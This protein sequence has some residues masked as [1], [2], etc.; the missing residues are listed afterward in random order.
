MRQF[1]NIDFGSGDFRA[2]VRVEENGNVEWFMRNRTDNRWYI[3]YDHI[4]VY[5]GQDSPK[6]LEKKYNKNL[7]REEKLKRILK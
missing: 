1:F 4:G 7:I 3:L 5:D 6:E 2:V